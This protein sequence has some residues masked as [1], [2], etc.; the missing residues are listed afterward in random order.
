ML[1]L[2]QFRLYV[3]RDALKKI[4]MHSQAA[5][6]LLLG[7]ALA[8]SDLTYIKQ[9]HTTNSGAYGLYQCELVTY[10]DIVKYLNRKPSLSNPIKAIIPYESW[11]AINTLMW[12]MQYATL[13]ARIHYWRITYPLPDADDTEGLC[14]YYL[15]HYNTSLGKA[16]FEKAIINFEK[17]GEV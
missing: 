12:D 16:T 9:L 7:T 5:E 3:V 8:E 4:N 14:N 2:K 10:N 13:R 1:N 11:P 15:R 17:A 6:N